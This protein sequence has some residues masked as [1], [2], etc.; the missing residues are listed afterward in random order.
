MESLKNKIVFITGATSGIGKAC[1]EEFA[2]AGSNL[3]LCARRPD[4]LNSISEG[5]RTEFG[6]K[7]FSFELDVRDRK[8]VESAVA[9]FPEEWKAIDILV[10]NAGLA[11][12]MSKF[13]EDDPDNWEEMI[14]TNV[15]GLLYVSHAVVPLMVKRNSGHIINLGS[16]AGH[17]PYPKGSVYCASKHAVDAITKSLRMDLVETNIRVSSIDPGMVETNFSVIRF[18]GD[19]EKAKNVYRGLEPLTG[20]DIAETILFMASRPAHVVIADVVIFPTHQ[21][22]ATISYKKV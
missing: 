17:E 4:L 16:I 11:K 20:K 13:Y 12:G 2:R 19:E 15:K 8:A 18:G 22:S 6:V 5:L 14:D 1:A 7:V 21:A 9:S 3:I 10:N